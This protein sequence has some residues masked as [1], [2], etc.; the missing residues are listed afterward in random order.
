MMEQ[1]E[2]DEKTYNDESFNKNIIFILDGF[3][4]IMGE[5]NLYK[6]NNIKDKFP[7]AKILI[8][9]RDEYL[10]NKNINENKKKI[11]FP[12]ELSYVGFSNVYLRNFSEKQINSYLSIYSIHVPN[13]NT[14]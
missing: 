10:S 4:E 14:N 12:E 8:T 9:C 5:R 3:D 2:I 7:E 6:E 1:Y 11:F 13:K